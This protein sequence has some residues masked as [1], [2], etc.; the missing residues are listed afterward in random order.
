MNHVV[1]VKWGNKY[2]SQYANILYNMVKRHTTVPFEFHCITDNATGLDTNIGGEVLYGDPN[3]DRLAFTNGAGTNAILS[4]NGTVPVWISTAPFL[5]ANSVTLNAVPINDNDTVFPL[6]RRQNTG[7]EDSVE[8]D[9]DFFYNPSSNRLDV[10]VLDVTTA[11]TA[12]TLETSGNIIVNGV[13][14]LD[15]VNVIGDLQL[16]GD[17]SSTGRLLDS[18]GRS[19]VIFD[20]AGQLLWGNDGTG[21]TP[22]GGGGGGA[23]GGGGGIAFTDLEV[24]QQ[25]ASGGGSLTYSDN[26]VTAGDFFYSPAELGDFAFSAT[27]IDNTSG[28]WSVTDSVSFAK[29]VAITGDLI[30]SGEIIANGAGTPEI[31]SG[32]AIELTATTRVQVNNTP[33]R[34]ATLSADPVS[35]SVNGDMYYNTTTHKFRGYANSA[36]VD[37]N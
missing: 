33:F 26:G 11:I 7:G 13:S 34:L 28:A 17:A 21:G 4:H 3:V 22:A 5:N 30:V 35:G 23:G 36:W 8:F 37:L 27:Q 1:C 15:S 2:V 25:S 32:S 19:F 14:N 16:S 20:S 31:T 12:D 9:T 18:A 10:G 29:A 24:I 6:F